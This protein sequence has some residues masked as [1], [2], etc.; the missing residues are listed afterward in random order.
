MSVSFRYESIVLLH[1]IAACALGTSTAAQ[2][3]LP[4]LPAP[5]PM[6][7]VSKS[8]RSQLD[9]TRDGKARLRETMTLA[10]VRLTNAEKLTTDKN[11]AEAL[12]ELGGYLGLIG[13]LRDYFA[14]MDATKNSTRDLYR[15]FEMQVRPHIPRLA[16]IQRTTPAPYVRNLKDAEDFIKETRSEALESFYGHSVLKEAPVEKALISSPGTVKDSIP[17]RRP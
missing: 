2:Q 16:V 13:D 1:M 3:Q 7:F 8:E 14:R 4:R 9:G 6:Q 10:E 5:P 12:A 15:H 17:T 11:F